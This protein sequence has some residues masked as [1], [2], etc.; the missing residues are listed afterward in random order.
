MNTLWVGLGG[1]VGSIARYHVGE[2]LN[3]PGRALP[4]GTLAVNLVGSFLIAL[5]LQLAL[6][7]EAITPAIRLALATGVLGG[8]T[9]YS[10]F[11]QETLR[12][13]QDGAWASA[14]GYVAITLLGGLAAGAAGWA[15]GRAL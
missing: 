6:R 10:T 7:H 12:I 2:W 3:R 13:A 8:F 9:T 15:I 14:A 4:W 11:N 5:L 1:A